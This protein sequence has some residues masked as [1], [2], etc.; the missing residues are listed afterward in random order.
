MHRSRSAI[1]PGFDTLRLLGAVLVLLSHSYLIAQDSEASE[2]LQLLLKGEKNIA[3]LY[4]VFT[5]FIISGYLLARS[6]HHNPSILRFAINRCMRLLPGFTCCTLF[7]ALV[8]GPLC[9][10]LNPISYFS[11]GGWLPYIRQSLATLGDAPLPGVFNY[12]GS[13]AQVV[14][15]S[16]WSLQAEALC[17]V[18]LLVLWIVLPS[19]GWVAVLLGTLG[20]SILIQPALSTVIPVIGYPL[21]YFA[22][23]V[24][25]WWLTHHLGESRPIAH[26]CAAGLLAGALLGCP[27]Q[28]FAS[29]GAYLVIQ[30]GH[31]RSPI[32][33]WIERTGDLSYG[34][35]LFGWPVQQMLRQFLSLRDPLLMFALST[36]I[37]LVLAWCLFHAVEKPAMALRQPLLQWFSRWRPSQIG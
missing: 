17:Y 7:C 8:V 4:G 28:A 14:N 11:S 36:V 5:F 30:I 18:L 27:H 20:I 3:G 21:P 1:L 13:I 26:L 31:Q 16:L 29:F 25:V 19:P 22:A 23:G 32:S 33:G 12:V 15:G 34:L 2:P 9:S 24:L 37:T 10:S 35:Y 6:L